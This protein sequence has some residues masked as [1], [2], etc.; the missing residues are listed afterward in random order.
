MRA[1]PARGRATRQALISWM[2]NHVLSPTSHKTSPY[3][4]SVLP[5]PWGIKTT[6]KKHQ[7]TPYLLIQR[8]QCQVPPTSLP[9]IHSSMIGR[10]TRNFPRPWWLIWC[11]TLKRL[12]RYIYTY[13]NYRDINSIHCIHT[14]PCRTLHFLVELLIWG[15][16]QRLHFP[17]FRS[18]QRFPHVTCF[19]CFSL[20]VS[21]GVLA[22][23]PQGKCNNR[24]LTSFE[25]V[26]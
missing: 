15:R 14:V 23:S 8:M 17:L 12:I 18:H 7:G 1:L 10:L 24:P 9:S 25:S 26:R 13:H 5:L 19:S 3:W 21:W 20:G 6:N 11:F 16:W 2:L 4:P 22:I